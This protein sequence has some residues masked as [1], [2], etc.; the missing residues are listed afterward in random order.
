M[1][2]RWIAMVSF[3]AAIASGL[4]NGSLCACS[5]SAAAGSAVEGGWG[6][7]RRRRS[8]S[9]SE[10]AVGVLVEG[11]GGGNKGAGG[12]PY[13][14]RRVPCVSFF[15]GGFRHDDPEETHPVYRFCEF[16]D[17]VPPVL[18]L[19]RGF[20]VA[21]LQVACKREQ[22]VAWAGRESVACPFEAADERVDMLLV[23]RVGG[24]GCASQLREFFGQWVHVQHVRD[25]P[26]RLE[27]EVTDRVRSG[28]GRG[29]RCLGPRLLVSD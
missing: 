6:C 10:V 22:L 12:A 3:R 18:V 27:V 7:R 9:S 8:V 15:I 25:W 21:R 11:G 16:V 19:L 2:A 20:C 26:T 17:R 5:C 14:C 28:E 29:E 13:F 23:G 24:A 1:R 4:L